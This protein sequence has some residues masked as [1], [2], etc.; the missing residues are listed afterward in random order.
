MPSLP[1]RKIAVIGGGGYV[2][3]ALVPFLLKAGYQ[4]KVF[5]LFLFGTEFFSGIISNPNL[6]LIQ[7]DIRNEAALQKELNGMDAVIHLACVSNDPSFELDP[8]LGRSINF[9]AFPGLLRAV[10]DNGVERLIYA[11]SSSV[12]GVKEQP[13]IRED[14]SCEPLTDYSKYK[15]QCEET[16]SHSDLGKADYVILRPATVCGFA[17][18][19]RLDLTVN[20]LTIH[21]L[22]NKKMRVFGGSQLRPNINIQDMIA[23]YQ[24]LLESPRSKVHREVFN[25]GY[26]NLTV[27]EIAQLVKSQLGDPSIA[28]AIEPSQDPRSYHV[29]SDKI[30]NILGFR[31]R[32]T[33]EQAVQ[34]IAE[35]YRAGDIPDPLKRPVY[36]NLKVMQQT[37]LRTPRTAVARIR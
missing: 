4:I 32:Y 13:D 18:R 21:A 34:S 1:F 5:D 17:P 36:Y 10:K 23:V 11:S 33:V 2:G 27:L 6:T 19:L 28:I 3:S 20:I 16:L 24:L 14:D 8:A 31:P 29:N 12:Y 35:A 7:A 25:A 22:V 9:D 15:L 30:A 26:C 37:N